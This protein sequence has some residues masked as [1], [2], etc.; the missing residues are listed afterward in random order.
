[1]ESIVVPATSDVMSLFSRIIVLASVDFPA[2]GRP[3]KANFMELSL[4]SSA[5][6]GA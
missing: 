4:K 2:L 3:I 5:I 6:S 1:M